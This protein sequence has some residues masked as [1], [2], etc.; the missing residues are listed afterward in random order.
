[1]N[2]TL[3]L[4]VT[5]LISKRGPVIDSWIVLKV[6]S[7]IFSPWFSS[8]F[9]IIF[10]ILTQTIEKGWCLYCYLLRIRPVICLNL[11][12]KPLIISLSYVGFHQDPLTYKI[13]HS[14]K[15]AFTNRFY[16]RKFLN[17][18]GLLAKKEKNHNNVT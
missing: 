12:R 1:M 7:G 13:S 5:Y 15:L 8:F 18:I 17:S 4:R 2:F 10:Q 9:L 14:K 11:N 3:G 16:L 6:C